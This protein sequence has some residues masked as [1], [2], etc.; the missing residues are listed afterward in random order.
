M[1]TAVDR[2]VTFPLIRV[3]GPPL[4]R[5]R[6][7]GRQAGQHIARAVD[8][9][10]A[11]FADA[12]MSWPQALEIAARF[13]TAI[14]E[15]DKDLEVEM[16]GIAAGAEQQV[17]TI[18]ALNARIELLQWRARA[19]AMDECTGVIAL[20]SATTDGHLL[21]AQNWDWRAE[22]VDVAVVLRVDSDNGPD[23]LTFV[24]AGQLARNGMNSAGI[25]I[26]ANGLHC[27]SDGGRTGVPTTCVRRRALQASTLTGAMDE[28]MNAPRAYSHNLMIA[29]ASGIAVDFE[30]TP[31]DVFWIE[32]AQ[33]LLVH[34][35]HFKSA[36]A[37]SRVTDTGLRLNADSL[38]RDMRVTQLLEPRRGSITIEDLKRALGDADGAPLAVCRSPVRKRD[39]VLSSTVA[40]VI[41][42]T[43]ERRMWVAPAPYAGAHYTEYSLS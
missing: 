24:E 18:V 26:T 13:R 20:P 16:T 14:A 15:Y 34:A 32:P 2:Q 23:I 43:T 29:S 35:N 42:D 39:G 28:V 8:I 21:H 10:R 12:G 31:D 38:H 33:G 1:S 9:Y 4:E 19:A 11:G 41:M 3:A 37:L 5:G 17:E 6:Q 30:T 36:A 25:S 40:T 27:D 7:Y 22:C